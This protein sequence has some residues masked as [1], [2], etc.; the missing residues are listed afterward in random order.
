MALKITKSISK[1]PSVV[2]LSASATAMTAAKLMAEHNVGAIM[3]MENGKLVGIFTERD[4]VK[5]VVA[6]GLNPAQTTIATVMTANPI[7]LK[8]GE[9]V[10]HALD[11]MK[12]N[13]IR[14]LPLEENG[15]IIGMVSIRDLFAAVNDDLQENIQTKDAIIFGETYGVGP[16]PA[17]LNTAA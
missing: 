2:K 1:N 13:H 10:Y 11:L 7:R 17:N 8:S 14:H 5:R 6:A 4:I 16:K 9:S 15:E 3:I 12:K